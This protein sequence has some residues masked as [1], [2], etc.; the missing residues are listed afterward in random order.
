LDTHTATINWGDGNTTAG[1]VSESNGAGTVTGGHAYAEEGIYTA[2]LTV[3]DNGGLSGS[4]SFNVTVNDA[5]PT[6]TLSGGSSVNEGTSYVL[7]L[8]VTPGPDPVTGWTIN[9]GDGNTSNVTGSPPTVAHTYADGPKLYT[10]TATGTTDDGTLNANSLV[11]AINNI[12]PAVSIS[13]ASSVNEGSTYTLNLSAT[14]DSVDSDAITGWSINWGDGNTQSYSGNPSSATHVYI[15]AVNTYTVSASALDADGSYAS[16]TLSVAVNEVAPVVVADS[17]T[18][19]TGQ[20]LTFSG[21]FTDAGIL[22]THTASINW[23]DNSSNSGTVT[24]AGGSGIVSGTHSYSTAGTYTVTLTVTDERNISGT[25]T[26]TATI[27][28]TPLNP[29]ISGNSSVNEGATYTLNLSFS[30]SPAPTSWQVTWGDGNVSNINGNPSST[31]HSYSD[32]PNKVTISATATNSNGTYASNAL[33]VTVNAINPTVSI[34]GASSV[35][36]GSTYTLTL[37]STL[38]SVDAD[39]I[40][41]WKVVWGD[42]QTQD[43]SG[44][45]SSVTHVYLDGAHTYTASA[46]AIDENGSYSTNNLTITVNNVAPVVNTA[47]NVSGAEGALVSFAGTFTDAGVLDTHTATINWGDGNTTNGSVQEQNGAG[48]VT[49]THYYGETGSYTITLTVKD[50]SNATGS[51]TST[52]TISNVNPKVTAAPDLYEIFNQQFT[53]QVASFT[54]PG[55]ASGESYSATINWGDGSNTV[56]G[57]VAF[58][59]GSGGTPTTGTVSGTYTYTTPGTYTITVT[60]KDDDSTPASGTCTLIAHVAAHGATKFFVVDQSAH[61]IFA[62]DKYGNLSGGFDVSHNNQKPWGIATDAAMDKLWIVDANK[63]IQVYIY[64]PDGTL[65]GSWIAS[66]VTNA[67]DITTDGANLWIADNG[68]DKVD[69]FAGGAGFLKGTH[70]PTWTFNLDSA[71]QYPTGMV[72]D[73]QTIWIT[74]DHATTNNVFVYNTLGVKLGAWHLDSADTTPSGI[75]LN[76]SYV[77]GQATDLWVVDKSTAKAY[78]YVGGSAWT[79]GN[80]SAGSASFALASGDHFPEG[81]ADPTISVQQ[82]PTGASYPQGS[83]YLVSGQATPSNG[84]TLQDVLVNGSAVTLDAGNN[85]F[86]PETTDIGVNNLTVTAIDSSGSASTTASATGTAPV[87]ASPRNP[88]AIDFSLLSDVT[89]SIGVAYGHTSFNSGTNTLYADFTATNNGTYNIGTSFLVGVRHISAPSVRVIG[90]TGLLP[91]DTPFFDLSSLVALGAG[92]PTPPATFTPGESLNPF[93]LSFYDPE[94]VTFTY[95]LVFLGHLDH[96]PRFTSV[97][98]VQVVAGQPYNYTTTGFSPDGAYLSFSVVSG[99]AGLAFT[100]A[101][102]GTL[103]WSPSTAG[104]YPIR[105]RVSDNN[106]G[107]ADQVFILT[108]LASGINLPPHFTSAPVVDARVNTAYNYPATAVDLDGD[109]LTFSLVSG[110]AGLTINS[111]TGVV[112]WTPTASQL[113]LQNVTLQVADSAGAYDQQVYQILVQQPKG[114]QPPIF[115]TTA[116]TT[117]AAGSMYYYPSKAIDADGD[118][119]TYTL[120]Q[121]PGAM[122]IDPNTGKIYWQTSAPEVGNNYPVT[123]LASD[124][125]GATATQSFT[126]NVTSGGTAPASIFGTKYNDLNGNGTRDWLTNTVGLPPIA[127][128]LQSVGYFPLAMDYQQPTNSM[129]VLENVNGTP[130]IYRLQPDGSQIL[131]ASLPN[132]PTSMTSLTTVRPGNTAGFTTG[133]VFVPANPS[134]GGNAQILRVSNGGATV[135]NPWVTLSSQG[136]VAAVYIDQTG[137]FG[138]KLLAVVDTSYMNRTAE[139]WEIDGSGNTTKLASF[140][141][142]HLGVSI[143]EAGLLTVPN[144]SAVYG[145]LAGKA[146]IVSDSNSA[147]TVDASGNVSIP[148]GPPTNYPGYGPINY[149]GTGLDNSEGAAIV[150]PATNFFAIADTASNNISVADGTQFANI[151][152]QFIV[153]HE[154]GSGTGSVSRVWWDGTY[155]QTA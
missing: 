82:P 40:T 18:G 130:T 150:L 113:G 120:T 11:L 155:L 97:P 145:P 78:D 110:P 54:D 89:A 53:S 87:T 68:S 47:S 74:D 1:T 92:L 34:S 111:S 128:G 7:T 36:E 35:N 56:N 70:S 26:G 15:D 118:P 134:G 61:H 122:T 31:T 69:Y 81:I 98:V 123:I 91:D 146:L 94:G 51:L 133:H 108:V 105:L 8:G 41:E 63:N 64:K 4:V 3:T 17:L 101:H 139:L 52:A 100:D 151:L 154:G 132:S 72:T 12:P 37:S 65:L 119:I 121:A 49:G 57:T 9:W 126:I 107:T 67:R 88:G 38:D 2:T 73:G 39:P 6:L 116:V 25:A 148:H 106:G 13:G 147:I 32:G 141:G 149:S 14:P 96:P 127:M 117:V 135:T 138:D 90:N 44:N 16:N 48:I 131:Y 140:T 99:P 10:I 58:T 109:A 95:D 71:N 62:Y 104:N 50:D 55:F 143:E 103:A 75:T 60:V 27:T 19:Q 33:A 83:P 80:H 22:D 59:L 125:V 21:R 30:G 153:G 29:T 28:A 77:R 115:V 93:S 43:I 129:L 24:E 137:V 23:G 5:P 144:S 152:G 85:F 66:G 45:P 84:A 114:N 124:G 86:A 46:T 20:T 102:A 136:D 42:N 142:S 112:T 76:P 79:S